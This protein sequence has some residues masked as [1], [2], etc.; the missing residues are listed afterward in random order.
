MIVFPFLLI[1]AAQE[2]S[3]KVPPDADNF[4]PNEFPHFRVFCNIQLSRPATPTE[5][6]ENAVKIAAIPEDKIRNITMPECR[7]LGIMF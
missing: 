5:H 4:D 6:W 2:A 7:E 1:P 3:M